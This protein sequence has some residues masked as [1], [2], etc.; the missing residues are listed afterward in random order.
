MRLLRDT[1]RILGRL[2]AVYS[3][4]EIVRHCF[5]F[6]IS[7][8]GRLT[9]TEQNQN[10]DP[11]IRREGSMRKA[12]RCSTRICLVTL[13]PTAGYAQLNDTGIT[14]CADYAYEEGSGFHNMEVDCTMSTDDQGDPVPL[15]Q[16]GHFGRDVTHNDDSDGRAG[17]SFTKIDAAGS[18]LA[19]AAGSWEC[20]RD[21]VT[22]LMWEVKTND[23]GLRDKD[24]TYTW[25]DP[26]LNTNGGDAGE[27][28]GGACFEDMNCDTHNFATEVNEAGLCGHHDW[29]LPRR[30]ELR[31]ILDYSVPL[32]GPKIDG[33]WFPNCVSTNFWSGSTEA[34]STNRAW[35]LDF[36]YSASLHHVK[37]TALAVRLVRGGP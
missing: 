1:K 4:P 29:R 32:P 20:V 19:N 6:E 28:N 24:W 23:G 15:G 35:S 26:D 37:G 30:E 11:T 22:G 8:A 2:C 13:L 10:S 21:N 27:V 31:S 33:N 36:A 25:Y 12:T 14:L 17:F 9:W 5:G 18:V 34:F 7:A 16:D 3:F